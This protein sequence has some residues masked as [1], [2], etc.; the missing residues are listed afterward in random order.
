MRTAGLYG[1]GGAINTER[2]YNVASSIDDQ[3]RLGVVLSQDG[4]HVP[5]FNASSAGNPGTGACGQRCAESDFVCLLS[6]CGSRDVPASG[7]ASGLPADSSAV[8]AA[9]NE[10]G[11]VL[12]I[13][14]WG[15]NDLGRWL[16]FECPEEKRGGVSASEVTFSNLRIEHTPPPMPPPLPPSPPPSPLPHMPPTQPQPL[17]PPP[18]SPSPS[19]PPPPPSPPPP[20]T[21]PL[22]PPPLHFAGP[23]PTLGLLTAGALG[24]CIARRLLDRPRARA[25]WLAARAWLMGVGGTGGLTRV[26]SHAVSPVEDELVA[27]KAPATAPDPVYRRSEGSDFLRDTEAADCTGS[28]N[29]CQSGRLRPNGNAARTSVPAH[30][31]WSLD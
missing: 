2:P 6:S 28:G 1:P 4:V 15:D 16:D 5:F 12:V 3:G 11:M 14:L 24:I 29:G 8:V 17:L 27:P 30:D 9:A 25:L 13:S 26:V 7:P 21:P 10:A 22:Q 19:P 31:V 23:V 20:N 18:P